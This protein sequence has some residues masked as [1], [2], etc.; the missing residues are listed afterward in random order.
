MA[1]WTSGSA[2][3]SPAISA[4]FSLSNSVVPAHTA[5]AVTVSTT[6]AST[7]STPATTPRARLPPCSSRAVGERTG[8]I[9]VSGS[10]VTSGSTV[11]SASPGSTVG[12]GVTRAVLPTGA[13]GGSTSRR[14]SAGCAPG[15]REEQGGA[16]EEAQ[17]PDERAQVRQLGV[18]QVAARPGR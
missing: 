18:P 13:P 4:T 10:I 12:G 11:S 15:R 1:A 5:I 7:P 16:D 14:R 6:I 3:A 8:S 17:R 9:V 2:R